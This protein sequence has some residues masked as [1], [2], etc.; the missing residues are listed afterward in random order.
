MSIDY[1][2]NGFIKDGISWFPVMGEFQ[3][4]RNDFRYWKSG[5]AKMKSLGINTVAS[6]VIWIHHEEVQGQFDFNGNN[7]L[8]GFLKE[9]QQAGLLCCLRIGPWVHGEVRNGGFPDWLM[10]SSFPLR[11][12]S[13]QY[14]SKVEIF[15]KKI[16]EQCEGF[17]YKEG[18][19]IYAIQVE[20]EYIVPR[21]FL[22]GYGDEHIN[23]LIDILEEIGFQVPIWLA[24]GWG[25][26]AIG[27]ALPVWGAYSEAPWEDHSKEL[28]PRNGY[29]IADNPND[30]DIGSDTGKKEMNFT[31]SDKPYPF[32]TVELGSGVQVTKQRRPIIHGEDC[33]AIAFCKLASGA[34]ALGYYVFHG[35]IN[36]I[37]KL[38]TMQEYKDGSGRAGFC[39][40]LPK[41]DY[42]FQAAISQYGKVTETGK[43]LKL[44]NYFAN[45]FGASVSQMPVYFPKD[46][47]IKADDFSHLRY[48]VRFNGVSGYLFFNAYI[49]H[50]N[51]QDFLLNEKI[52]AL[53]VLKKPFDFPEIRLKNKQFFLFPFC[54]GTAAGEIR[55]IN[56]T[57]Y[58][59]IG[60]RYVFWAYD[61]NLVRIDAP[62]EVKEKIILIS[63]DDALNAYKFTIDGEDLLIVSE[64]ELYQMDNRIMGCFSKTPIVKLFSDIKHTLKGWKKIDQ[65]QDYNVYCK[66]RAERSVKVLWEEVKKTKNYKV[67]KID[68]DY[69]VR[70]D[71]LVFLTIDFNADSI[72]IYVNDCMILDK[73]YTGIPVD[74]EL[75][76]YNYPSEIK[77]RIY[78]LY[79]GT[80]IYIEKENSFVDGIANEIVDVKTSVESKEMLEF[81]RF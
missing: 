56:A 34:S 7:N 77:V 39:S 45:E 12:N 53:E 44:W 50:Y 1:N 65:S 72:E 68:L 69:K 11:C 35:G 14:L 60:D 38:T 28:S 13:P 21:P 48:S 3:Y 64:G 15:F 63:R 81:H 75:S 33:S 78:P 80:D 55:F 40:D 67:Y 16:Y 29:L 5:L 37:G 70:K 73:F 42:D 62:Q 57:P 25:N 49:R 32:I 23:K 30:A 24:T 43:E 18:G 19:P 76:R 59:R 9:I 31:I 22:K 27:R 71:D 79:Q 51:M 58:C 8:R 36:P 2:C 20:N 41:L 17:F 46:N 10:N 66:N 54:F 6:Y 47:P 26:A 61:P 74:V 52:E 4:S